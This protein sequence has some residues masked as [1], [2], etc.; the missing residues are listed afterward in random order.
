MTMIFRSSR[1]H[2]T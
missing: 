1:L 2:C